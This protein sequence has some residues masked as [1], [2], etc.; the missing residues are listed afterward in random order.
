MSVVQSGGG[1]V[2]VDLRR[3]FLSLAV[4]WKR[5]LVIALAVTAVAFLLASIA[6]PQYQAET[7][8]LIEPRESVFTRPQGEQGAQQPI[9]DEEGVTSQV[10]VI[11]S[12]DI[13]KQVAR[14]FDLASR[15]EFDEAI[16][17]SPITRLLVI[18]GLKNDPGEIPADE[19]VLK[20]FREK[21]KVYRVEKSRVIVIQFSSEDPKLSADVPNAIADAYLTVSRDAK[22]LSNAD[23]TQWLEPEIAKLTQRV[24]EAEAQV[25]QFRSQS[26][27]MVGGNNTSLSTQQLAELSSELTRVRA[28]RAAAEANAQSVRTILN[29]GGSLETLPEVLSSPLIQRLREKSVELKASVADLSTSLLDNHPRIRAL[30]SQIADYDEQIRT[31][32][33]SLLQGL[34]NEVN[35][36]KAREAQ[37]VADQNRLKAESSRV[38]EKEVELRA[39]EREATA[40][41]E[42]LESYLT[43]YREAA[44]R[45]DGN[46]LPADARIFSRA[47][48]PGEPYFPKVM[49][50]TGAAFAGSL[51]LLAIATLLGELFSGRAFQPAGTMR[52]ETVRQLAMPAYA[53]E[54]E[55]FPML[56]AANQA[57]RSGLGEIGVR[58]AADMLISGGA[59]RALFVSPEGD[60]AAA[61]SVMVAREVADAGLRV[62]LVDL[63][64]SG[65]AARP[66]LDGAML[67]GITNLLALEAQFADAIHEDLYSDCHI[68]PSGTANP[69]KAMRAVDR[70]PAIME[71]LSTV[72]DVVIIECGPANAASIRRLVSNGT[73]IM[74]SVIESAEKV[75]AARRNLED[76]GYDHLTLVTPGDYGKP[77]EPV[78]DRSA[79]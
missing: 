17:M 16:S 33:R 23:A 49:P 53:E 43:R 10:E 1:D 4:R 56:E 74:V 35:A 38:G 52:R 42:L 26:D 27:L 29:S 15:A 59:T 21:L 12:T 34:T 77:L 67:P 54:E 19:R 57:S 11:G 69:V 45:R 24:K 65:A 44:S 6:T 28:N 73:E 13:L 63:T 58:K 40:Q 64:S 9:L 36:A 60:E 30:R 55:G 31:E 79:A 18:A 66:M 71:S 7:R 32:A 61:S 62:I 70:L 20:A 75:A 14:K 3:L 8:I 25:A 68:I 48:V 37:L 46:Y 47:I 78:R 39:L 51:L 41:R 2:D 5:I 22:L 76:G 50:I 72:Y